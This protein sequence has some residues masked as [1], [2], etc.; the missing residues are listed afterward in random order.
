VHDVNRRVCI[1]RYGDDLETPFVR[2]QRALLRA[3]IVI[4]ESIV[5]N[6]NEESTVPSIEEDDYPW[7]IPKRGDLS[8]W[9]A[10]IPIWKMKLPRVRVERFYA[11]A[12]KKIRAEADV[13]GGCW[14]DMHVMKAPT[15]HS[16]HQTQSGGRW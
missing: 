1:W 4:D 13:T 15:Q 5:A 9:V 11:H 6:T 7:R 12:M 14:L 16:C 3:P 10:T 2:G 8:G